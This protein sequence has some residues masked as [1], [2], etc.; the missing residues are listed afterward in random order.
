LDHLQE[1][2]YP[3]NLLIRVVTPIE[4]KFLTPK[5]FNASPFETLDPQMTRYRS[6]KTFYEFVNIESSPKELMILKG[7]KNSRVQFGPLCSRRSL[8]RL[9]LSDKSAI[10][11]L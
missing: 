9:D 6:K 7:F 2:G 8:K 3:F 10:I 5:F 11:C 1:N 4:G